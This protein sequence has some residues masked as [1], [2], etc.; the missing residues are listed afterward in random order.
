MPR[1]DDKVT[2][3]TPTP[4]KGT[5]RI[6]RWKYDTVRAAILECLPASGEGLQFK[7]LPECVAGKLPAEVKKKLGS[8]S[9]YATVVKLDLECKGEIRRVEGAKPQRLV[10][11]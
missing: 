8:I 7:A 1:P 5:I 3:S 9:W 4:G 6:A 2:C 11:I 10:K